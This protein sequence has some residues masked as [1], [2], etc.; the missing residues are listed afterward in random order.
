MDFSRDLPLIVSMPEIELTGLPRELR[1]LHTKGMEALQRDNF[2]Y[3]VDLFM[4]RRQ[5]QFSAAHRH[6]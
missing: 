2:D 6:N 1:Q 3:A 5:Q 4:H